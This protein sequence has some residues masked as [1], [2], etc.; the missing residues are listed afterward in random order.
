MKSR[1]VVEISE[2]CLK[3]ISTNSS[4]GD[5]QLR[6]AS[7][8]P[9]EQHAGDLAAA[10]QAMLQSLEVKRPPEITIVFSR[11][12]ITMRSLQL[13]SKSELE[14][15][16]MIGLHVMRQVPFPKEDIIWTYKNLGFD[17]I[18]NSSVLLGVVNKEVLKEVFRASMAVK[19]FPE[20]VCLSSRGIIFFVQHFLK[21]KNELQHPVL[22][23]DVDRQFSELLLVKKFQLRSSVMINLGA[24]SL[25]TDQDRERLIAEVKQVLPVFS[26]EL[27]G[28][29]PG[30]LFITGAPF[31]ATALNGQMGEALHM[32]TRVV[33][34]QALAALS[35]PSD[36]SFSALCGFAFQ[37]KTDEF[38]FMFPEAKVRKDMRQKIRQLLVAGISLVYCVLILS[39][40]IYSLLE[41]RLAYREK[42]QQRLT[43]L[44]AKN[45]ELLRVER[46]TRFF[47]EYTQESV[48]EYLN[49]LTRILPDEITLTQFTWDIKKGPQI[50]GYA[51][52]PADIFR[53][54]EIL[55]HSRHFKGMD[56][57]ATRSSKHKEKGTIDFDMSQKRQ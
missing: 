8:H 24:E 49:E 43:Q 17:G 15:E 40:G 57:D 46:K 11:D 29:K 34:S 32:E 42:L 18:G 3:G 20:S 51:A 41:Q 4:P 21:D 22:I 45:S 6:R 30:K 31:C 52:N 39:L 7:V 44:E 28:E 23:L 55:G 53:F 36:Y 48:L 54:S 47:G 1:I 26:N 50:R 35:A 19:I 16:Q 10:F 9:L 27:P 14:I 38:H 2:T 56:V 33:D 5:P 13:P 37:K 12:K 25:K